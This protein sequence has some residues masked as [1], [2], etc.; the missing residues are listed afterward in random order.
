MPIAD[1]SFQGSHDRNS[2][3]QKTRFLGLILLLKRSFLSDL[4]ESSF[5]MIL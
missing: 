2:A 3:Y 1:T 5:L 4:A